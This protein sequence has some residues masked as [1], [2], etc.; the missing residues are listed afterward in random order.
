MLLQDGLVM[1]FHVVTVYGSNLCIC[2]SDG[3]TSYL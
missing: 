1:Q 3:A 2:E